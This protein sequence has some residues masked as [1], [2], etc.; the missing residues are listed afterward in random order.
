M[1]PREVLITPVLNG[2]IVTI[3]CSKV[4]FDELDTMAGELIRYY[5]S[6]V[7]VEKEYVIKAKNK[8]STTGIGITQAEPQAMQQ[9]IP[10]EMMRAIENAA[11]SGQ[12]SQAGPRQ[13]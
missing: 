7:K 8:L 3:G 5:E 10:P 1:L 9:G 11:S 6:P 4:V 13:F 2:W 12:D